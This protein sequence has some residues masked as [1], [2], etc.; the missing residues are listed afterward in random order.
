MWRRRSNDDGGRTYIA[1]AK[2]DERKTKIGERVD[3][4]G[5]GTNDGQRIAE[6]IS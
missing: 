1:K 6:F 5:E 3:N 2:G 4:Q